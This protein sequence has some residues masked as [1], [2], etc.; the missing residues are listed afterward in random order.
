MVDLGLEKFHSWFIPRE[1][2]RISDIAQSNLSLENRGLWMIHE[3]R[4]K[5]WLS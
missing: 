2:W 5:M 4:Q 1:G 3:L